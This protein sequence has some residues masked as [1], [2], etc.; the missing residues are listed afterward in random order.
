MTWM[1]M[2]R[3]KQMTGAVHHCQSTG[4]VEVAE[5]KRDEVNDVQNKQHWSPC[6]YATSSISRDRSGGAEVASIGKHKYELA[7]LEYASIRKTSTHL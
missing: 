4:E 3:L 2:R 7:G 1:T 5:N 6:G